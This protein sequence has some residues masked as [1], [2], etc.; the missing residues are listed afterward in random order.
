M[1]WLAEIFRD[2]DPVPADVMEL[3]RQSFA[4]RTLDAEL[5]ALVEDSAASA[6][7]PA[8]QPLTVRGALP[9]RRQLTFQFHDE[10]TDEDLIIAVEVE[11]RNR[12]RRLTG[13][14]APQG[15]AYIEVRQPAVPRARRVDVDRL[16]RFVVDDVLPGPASL[17]CRRAGAPSVATQWTLL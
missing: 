13:Q 11:S 1:S 10:Q 2:A 3:A 5:A 7:D 4:L 6:D 16:G 8:A 9:E 15:P 14:L 17:T 12:R